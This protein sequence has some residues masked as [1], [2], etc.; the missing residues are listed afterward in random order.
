MNVI[1]KRRIVQLKNKMLKTHCLRDSPVLLAPGRLVHQDT[2]YTASEL[3]DFWITKLYSQSPL[4]SDSD[5][6]GF[7]RKNAPSP[8]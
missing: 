3:P 2:A 4:K 7:H 5:L 8:S 1:N 6:A